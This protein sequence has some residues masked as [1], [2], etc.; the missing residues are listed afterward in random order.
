MREVPR[1]LDHYFQHPEGFFEA[2]LNRTNEWRWKNNA[3]TCFSAEEND[4]N[5]L[6]WS[7]YAK[8]GSVDSHRRGICLIFETGELEFLPKEPIHAGV[9]VGSVSEALP[10]TYTDAYLSGDPLACELIHSAIPSLLKVHAL[11]L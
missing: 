7:H 11:G 8:S 5:I 2:L 1:Q 10:V 3:V 6:M 4:C 9:L